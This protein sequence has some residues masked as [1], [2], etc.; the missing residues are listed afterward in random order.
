[1]L[2]RKF[3]V[4]LSFC[5]EDRSAAYQLADSLTKRGLTIF[6]D[7]WFYSEGSA[8]SDGLPSQDWE[9]TASV[10]VPLISKSYVNGPY[11]LPA[12]PSQSASL[13]SEEKQRV[14]PVCLDETSLPADHGADVFPGYNGKNA[15]EIAA[16]IEN[17]VIQSVK[18]QK[19][20]VEPVA[21]DQNDYHV[22]KQFSPAKPGKPV[23]ISR[24]GIVHL[25]TEQAKVP[26]S[27]FRVRIAMEL[28]KYLSVE[29]DISLGWPYDIWHHDGSIFLSVLPNFS[30][31]HQTLE[32]TV[33]EKGSVVRLKSIWSTR[34]ERYRKI[35]YQI[36]QPSVAKLTADRV[37]PCLEREGAI[38]IL[39]RLGAEFGFPLT[40]G[41]NDAKKLCGW[42]E[43][44]PQYECM[45]W[46]RDPRLVA[47]C[48]GPMHYAWHEP[49][50]IA[51][52]T[53]MLF[54]RWSAMA[55]RAL[56]EALEINLPSRHRIAVLGQ[57]RIR[58]AVFLADAAKRDRGRAFLAQRRMFAAVAR[59]YAALRE[60]PVPPPDGSVALPQIDE[61]TKT[62]FDFVCDSI[63][64][65]DEM[66]VV[67]A[68]EPD[69]DDAPIKRLSETAVGRSLGFSQ[70][71]DLDLDTL[72]THRD[73][74]QFVQRHE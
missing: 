41:E 52:L 19:P 14:L 62:R 44:L 46:G 27:G 1:M 45:E 66:E 55:L 21:P 10:V 20:P 49:S 71:P 7:E 73:I 51:I 31:P 57:G 64:K 59:M 63:L 38:R 26:P 56:N 8:R 32:F 43:Q 69:F 6:F 25:M 40:S 37:V 60:L 36:W 30:L 70:E 17:R 42:I 47:G 61:E 68:S 16:L 11:E 34:D 13:T 33:P 53:L 74:V 22:L 5:G 4:T 3:D 23:E 58:I 67:G 48:L 12:I 72:I 65:G 29:H 15:S 54:G 39:E 24:F 50:G 28:V 18:Q 35:D 9:V 2:S